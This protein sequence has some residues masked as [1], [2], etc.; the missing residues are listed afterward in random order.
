LSIK[1]MQLEGPMREPDCEFCSQRCAVYY[2][3]SER[4]KLC[5]ECDDKV[6]NANPV[7]A[8]HPRNFLCQ[9]C[10]AEPATVTCD[11]EQSMVCR[12]CDLST[13]PISMPD[14]N[15]H[16]RCHLPSFTVAQNEAANNHMSVSIPK[17]LVSGQPLLGRFAKVTDEES[18]VL[19][20][21]SG[22][23]ML[24]NPMTIA[25]DQKEQARWGA[26]PEGGLGEELDNND[27]DMW[28]RTM[29]NAGIV[30]GDYNDFNDF[31]PTTIEDGVS[32]L[33]EGVH[34]IE[35]DRRRGAQAMHDMQPLASDSCPTPQQQMQQQLLQHMQDCLLQRHEDLQRRE[36]KQMLEMQQLPHTRLELAMEN[37]AYKGKAPAD[38]AAW[39]DGATRSGD[40]SFPSSFRGES[41]MQELSHRRHPSAAL[42]AAPGR[43]AGEEERCVAEEMRANSGARYPWTSAQCRTE[44]LESSLK[45]I[46]RQGLGGMTTETMRSLKALAAMGHRPVQGLLDQEYG[47][48]AMDGNLLGSM[49]V[50]AAAQQDCTESPRKSTKEIRREALSRY[51][52]KKQ[53][54]TFE[55]TIRY[56]SRKV[57]ANGRVRIHGRFAR[58]VEPTEAAANDNAAQQC[59][60]PWAA[61]MDDEHFPQAQEA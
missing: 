1:P 13:H 61:M 39:L 33:E 29:E 27:Q 56:E 59:N 54:R 18:Q 6:H 23:A 14:L 12:M 21:A 48:S 4:I 7:A 58:K 2:C 47:R 19:Q 32:A 3:Q 22:A 26:Q 17:E 20:M 24:P 8:K 37:R 57:R 25:S 45:E 50:P 38:Q 44:T 60:E 16:Q 36:Q 49:S 30:P 34:M 15:Q 55:K 46:S 51:R 41:L 43:V 42:P 5:A 28:L 53:S 11:V 31:K 35:G 10:H 40:A 9:S 52:V